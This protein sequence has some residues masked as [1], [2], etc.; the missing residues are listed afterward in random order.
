MVKVLIMVALDHAPVTVPCSRAKTIMMELAS[1]RSRPSQSTR[2][3]LLSL[4][5][6]LV[7]GG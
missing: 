1:V 5:G 6:F 7:G 2:S 4:V 3:R